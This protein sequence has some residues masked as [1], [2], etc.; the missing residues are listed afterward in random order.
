MKPKPSFSMHNK[1]IKRHCTREIY[2]KIFAPA[3]NASLS[4]IVIMFCVGIFLFGFFMGGEGKKDIAIIHGRLN[5]SQEQIAAI[6]RQINTNFAKINKQILTTQLGNN[7]LLT[8][9]E[10]INSFGL[11][12]TEL[13]KW[14][15]NGLQYSSVLGKRY[16]FEQYIID[17]IK[18]RQVKGKP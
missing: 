8:E 11:T 4:V 7:I 17:F 14:R 1:P 15:D 18:A 13:R 10:V 16:Y 2:E 12:S 5:T 9:I 3:L 6:H